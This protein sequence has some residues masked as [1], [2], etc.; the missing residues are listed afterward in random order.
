MQGLMANG[1]DPQ[2]TGKSVK[3]FQQGSF[4]IQC[5]SLGGHAGYCREDATEKARVEALPQ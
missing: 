3:G 1:S 5:A 4:T 2:E